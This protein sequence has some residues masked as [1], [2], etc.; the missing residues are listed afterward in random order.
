MGEPPLTPRLPDTP[1]PPPTRVP[2][3]VRPARPGQHVVI[4]ACNLRK[5][6]GGSPA[7]DRVT[8]DVHRGEILALLGPSGCGKTTTLRLIAGLERPDEGYIAVSGRVVAD[9][10]VYVP[11]EARGIGLVF[12]DYALFPHLTIERNV[13]FGLHARGRGAAGNRAVRD[14]VAEMLALLDLTTFPRRYPHQLSGGQ[15]QRVALARALAPN[16]AVILLDE[17]FSNLD[18]DMRLTMRRDVQRILRQEGTTAVFVTHDQEEAFEVADRIGVL[19]SGRLEQIDT[20]EGLY[21]APATRFVAQFVGGADFIQGTVTVDGVRTEVGLFRGPTRFRMGDR[22]D[23][24]IRPVDVHMFP[25]LNGT[26]V[27]T[28]RHFHGS[29]N[30]YTVRLASGQIVHCTRPS[31]QIWHPGT[32][33]RPNATPKVLIAFAALKPWL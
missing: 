21:Q 14:R 3:A 31:G 5:R 4:A 6:F 12:Q 30:L 24:M 2:A 19:N 16:P 8:F 13:A 1:L 7:V 29:E 15:Q 22:V 23:V 26:A 28:E 10:R 33:V 11:P 17:P 18:A 27:I 20:P 32:R 25:A 9:G